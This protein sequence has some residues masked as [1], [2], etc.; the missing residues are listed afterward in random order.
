MSD[1]LE[2]FHA[3]MKRVL[4][5]SEDS[6]RRLTELYGSSLR[7][8][9]RRHLDR[10]LRPKFDSS[11]FLQDAWASFFLDLPRQRTFDDPD[12]LAAY[13]CAIAR[14]KVVEVH[15]QRVNGQ[16]YNVTRER[17]L[18]AS[19]AGTP[20]DDLAARQATPSTTAM[21]REEWDRLI[22]R[23][24]LVYRK[25]LLLAH[26]GRTPPEI[27]RELGVSDRQVRRILGKLLPGLYE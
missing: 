9:I 14:N 13:L 20:R 12:D 21:S 26:E 25:V 16:K 27:A 18:P 4:A 11:D 5:G 15:R 7:R 23:Q 6:A 24:P 22:E 19:A 1:D 10:R 8:A 17:P 2:E 3:L